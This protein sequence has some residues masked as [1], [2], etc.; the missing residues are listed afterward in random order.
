MSNYRTSRGFEQAL[1]E[2][3]R[4]LEKKYGRPADIIMQEFWRGRLLARIFHSGDSN[5]VL[6]GGTSLLARIPT[7]RRT[8]DLDLSIIDGR[9]KERA[10]E[11]LEFLTKI[12]LEDFFRFE[13]ISVESLKQEKE[14]L[15]IYRLRYRVFIGI[16]ERTTISID[17][18]LGCNPTAPIETMRPKNIEGLLLSNPPY[19]LYPLVDHIADKV[20]AII[21]KHGSKGDQESSRVKDLVDLCIIACNET[22]ESRPLAFAIHSEAYICGIF[23][24]VEFKVPDKWLTHP[25]QY[26]SQAKGVLIDE[27]ADNQDQ[28]VRLVKSF[29]DPVLSENLEQRIWRPKE[30]QWS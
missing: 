18:A 8:R 27:L 24:L 20:C 15:S 10:I 22:V 30:K 3:A 26:R 17:L 29:I 23:P 16:N 9:E 2:A 25:E 1:K 11:E 28:A 14:F 12:D 7:A 5:F 13:L 6:K 19:Q 21:E 4:V